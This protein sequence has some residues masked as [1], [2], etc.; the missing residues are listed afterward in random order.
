MSVMIGGMVPDVE[1]VQALTVDSVDTRGRPSPTVS[2]E[3]C[4]PFPQLARRRSSR[5]VLGHMDREI[6]AWKRTGSEPSLNVVFF[7]SLLVPLVCSRLISRSSTH[8][9]NT[10]TVRGCFGEDEPHD[11]S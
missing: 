6:P 2:D 7:L 9:Q 5:F 11:V 4:K 3:C 1:D 10:P 8:S